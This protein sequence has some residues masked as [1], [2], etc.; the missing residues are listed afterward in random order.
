MHTLT[1]I[2]AGA[3]HVTATERWLYLASVCKEVL[4]ANGCR[5]DQAK[6]VYKRPS[7]LALL[8]DVPIVCNL[9]I[10]ELL[11]DGLLSSGLIPGITHALDNY[12]LTHDAVV[13]PASATVYMQ[14]SIVLRSTS[15]TLWRISSSSV[16]C[17]RTPRI[18]M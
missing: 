7:D 11:D 3:R 9:L 6:V 1:A 15:K 8:E 4:V 17:K 2:N 18:H 13:I 5:D 14:A 10:A 12:L 16:R